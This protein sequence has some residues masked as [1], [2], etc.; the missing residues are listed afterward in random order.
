MII[1]KSTNIV[2]QKCYIGQTIR[3]LNQRINEHVYDSKNQ[4]SSSYF[5]RA[6]RK[7]GI[8]SFKWDILCECDTRDELDKKE[9]FWIGKEQSYV[10]NGGYNLTHGGDFNPMKYQE[11][12]DKI[13]IANKGRIFSH[14]SESIEKIKKF[15]Q[16]DKH[17]SI[18][19]W[20]LKHKDGTE[21]IIKN[22][23]K[24]CRENSLYSGH[25]RKVKRG[26][27]KQYKGWVLVEQVS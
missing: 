3:L 27:Y 26:I 19:K 2:N 25:M 8:K 13:S 10:R 9:I 16:S 5:H 14:T 18:K 22:L 20:L 6:I 1:Y 23:E 24:F 12:R 21:I 15:V 11:F 7:Y 4:K 17:P